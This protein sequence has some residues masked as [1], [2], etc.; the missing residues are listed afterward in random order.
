VFFRAEKNSN[1][2]SIFN[3]KGNRFAIT[4]TTIGKEEVVVESASEYVLQHQI[5][6]LHI[7]YADSRVAA[8]S[9]K[10]DTVQVIPTDGFRHEK[11]EIGKQQEGVLRYEANMKVD[12]LCFYLEDHLVLGTKDQSIKVVS[13]KEKHQKQLNVVSR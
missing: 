9:Q 6:Y 10:D 13:L 7:N 4:R 1:H 8:Y 2:L 5:D 3:T 12:T 11:H